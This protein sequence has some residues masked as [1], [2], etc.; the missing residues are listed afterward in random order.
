MKRALFP[1]PVDASPYENDFWHACQFFKC[2]EENEPFIVYF[3]HF[4]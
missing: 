1:Y 2:R 3:W 4:Q